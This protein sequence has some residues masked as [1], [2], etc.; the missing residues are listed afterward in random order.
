MWVELEYGTYFKQ[1][2][3]NH[4]LELR[5]TLTVV[6]PHPSRT[7][8]PIMVSIPWEPFSCSFRGGQVAGMSKRNC[9]HPFFPMSSPSSL[10]KLPLKRTKRA[11]MACTQSGRVGLVWYVWGEGFLQEQ[12]LVGYAL[13][14]WPA[15]AIAL[16]PHS[17]PG[18]PKAP[19]K[20]PM[21][22]ATGCSWDR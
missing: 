12:S 8:V 4:R 6:L 20:C 10:V 7:V 5:M 17:G 19:H 14:G 18:L 11:S 15:G 13:P 2:F 21:Q 16:V 22:M 1:C 3:C 9:S